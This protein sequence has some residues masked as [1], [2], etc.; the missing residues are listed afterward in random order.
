MKSMTGESVADEDLGFVAGSMFWMRGGFLT[1]LIPQIDLEGFE[2][3]PLEQDGSYAHAVERVIGMAALAQ[4]WHIGEVGNPDPLTRD[5]V[6][7]RTVRY[8]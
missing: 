7:H 2:P 3:E 5:D 4:G 8:L 1:S 6:R